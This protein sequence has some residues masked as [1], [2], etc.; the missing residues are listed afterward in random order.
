MLGFDDVFVSVTSGTL[1]SQ[2]GGQPGSRDP[3][4]FF[5]GA[6]NGSR[7]GFSV[8]FETWGGIWLWIRHI[9]FS[10]PNLE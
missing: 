2:V 3:A 8:S 9:Q 6:L 4:R 1:R 7:T 5:M 10:V